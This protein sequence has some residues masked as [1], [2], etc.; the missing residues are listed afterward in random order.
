[1]K[2]TNFKSS[3]LLRKSERGQT[4]VMLLLF[5]VMAIM[6]VSAAVGLIINNSKSTDK[7]Y[8]GSNA[9]SI[10]ESGIEIAMIKLI[11][12]SSYTGETQS[13][14]G[15]QAVIT[16]TGTEPKTIRSKATTG[17][18]T[19]TVEAIVTTVNYRL[20]ITSWREI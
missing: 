7:L 8:Q 19:R 12:N 20:T 9:L 13:I 2:I 15:G 6:V 14:G 11:R 1:M 5:M 10:A 18:F 16:V 4:L 3:K 17:D